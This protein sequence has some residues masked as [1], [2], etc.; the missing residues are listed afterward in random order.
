MGTSSKALA[1]KLRKLVRQ[2]HGCFTAAQAI[3][4]GYADSVHLYHVRNGKWVRVF[5]GVY[6]HAEWPE[7]PEARCMAAL[8]WTRDKIGNIQG[9][10]SP[11]TLKML[12]NGA[13]SPSDPIQLQVPKGFRRSAK[14]PKGILVEI[15]D[16]AG[17][18]TSNYGIFPILTTPQPTPIHHPP[19]MDMPDYYDWLDYQAVLCEKNG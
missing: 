11:N 9:F 7:T 13:L 14:I 1:E 5:R 19:T 6:R 12:Q 16:L 18:N 8:L 17:R 2:Q 4:V 15:L 3:E 10:L